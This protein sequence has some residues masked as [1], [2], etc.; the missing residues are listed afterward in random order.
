MSDSYTIHWEEGMFLQPHHLQWMQRQVYDRFGRE[1]S[2][3]CPYAY[4][5]IDAKLGDVTGGTI[6][7]DRLRA[8]MPSGR[9]VVANENATLAPRNDVKPKLT[10]KSLLVKLAVPFWSASSANVSANGNDFGR[11]YRTRTLNEVP[12]ENTG[13][14]AQPIT[15][16][17]INAKLLFEGEPENGLEVLPLLRIVP[18]PQRDLG[19]IPPCLIVTGSEELYAMVRDLSILVEHYRGQIYKQLTSKQVKTTELSGVQQEQMMRL[20]ILSRY[21]ARLWP[22]R[23]APELPIPPVSPFDLY[24]DLRELMSELATLRLD[25]DWA[26]GAMEYRHDD[27]FPAFSDICQRIKVLMTP[28]TG[29]LFVQT[30]FQIDGKALR[31]PLDEK[32]LPKA[33]EFYIGVQTPSDPRVVGLLTN[34]AKVHICAK[35]TLQTVL[36]G[37]RIEAAGVVATLPPPREDFQYFRLLRTGP[38]QDRWTEIERSRAVYIEEVQG[39]TTRLKAS[40][41]MTLADRA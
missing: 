6:R 27:L 31:A 4:G 14:R 30:E 1:R 25:R 10:G 12:D 35:D 23:R 8:V 3:V 20:Q 13:E 37:V 41:F 29:E 28:R 22:Y 40:L 34:P 32:N 16:R 39:D 36:E 9:E 7:F 26:A 19:F 15:V 5:I 24:V 38:S 18:G 21:S 11:L 33:R 17:E 2:L